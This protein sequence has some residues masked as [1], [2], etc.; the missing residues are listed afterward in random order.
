MQRITPFLTFKKDGK[1]AVEFY[2][3]IFKDS[4]VDHTTMMPGSEQLLHAGFT[5]DGQAFMAMDGGDFF[6]MKEGQSL[7]VACKD[8][9][10]VDYYWEA[11][12][13]DGGEHGECGWLTDKFG[14]SWQVVPTRLGELMGDPDPAKAGLVMRAMLKMTKIDIATLEAAYNGQTENT[15]L[16]TDTPSTAAADSSTDEVKETHEAETAQP[17]EITDDDKADEEA[18]PSESSGAPELQDDTTPDTSEDEDTKE[19]PK[20]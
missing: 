13:S 2:C 16:D 7:F 12:A 11:L 9:Q 4:H 18:K 17:A 6:E 5:L 10:E 15:D 3:T 20:N 8:Q 14:V 19:K 1:K